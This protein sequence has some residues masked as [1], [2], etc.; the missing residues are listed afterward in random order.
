ML[1]TDGVAGTIAVA[2]VEHVATGH[3]PHA[4]RRRQVDRPD[5]ARLGIGDKQRSP[6]QR[7]AGRL[8]ERCL[9]DMT[10]VPALGA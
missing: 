4:V 5:N 1:Q 6:G 9:V 2:E 7:E 3:G 10:I 8:R